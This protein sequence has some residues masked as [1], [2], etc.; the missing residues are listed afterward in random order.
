VKFKYEQCLI[1]HRL[2]KAASL[3]DS[4]SVNC[5]SKACK[6]GIIKSLWTLGN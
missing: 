6:I 3:L 4:E 2:R 1:W 5:Q